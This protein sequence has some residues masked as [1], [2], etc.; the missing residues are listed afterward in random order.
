MLAGHFGLAAAVKAKSPEVP[1]WAL[2]AAAQLI[3]IAFVPLLLT[4]VETIDASGGSG[5]GEAVI[6]ADYTH[7]LAGV[8]AIALL[9]GWAAAKAWGRRGG[10]TIGAVV[11]SHWLLDL[12][13]HRADLPL[14]PGN[15]GGLP[16]IGLGLWKWPEASAALEVVLIVAG[17]AM[18]ARSVL[19][20]SARMRRRG[21]VY[22]AAALMVVLL[23]ASLLTDYFG[24]L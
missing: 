3:D 19:R 7:S 5:Y 20:R 4:G 11:F 1:L 17:S 2:M 12:I 14:L 15:A 6:H 16:L 9:A 24:I 21:R 8:L 18:Y 13:V 22:A 23:G 10:F